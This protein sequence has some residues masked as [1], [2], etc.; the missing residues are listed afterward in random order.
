M[1][2]NEGGTR[3]LRASGRWLQPMTFYKTTD[4]K[5]L[6]PNSCHADDIVHGDTNTEMSA[7]DRGVGLPKVSK[8]YLECDSNFTLIKVELFE[9]V[10][11]Y[12]QALRPIR[13]LMPMKTW[14]LL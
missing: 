7:E 4:L 10:T 8:I 12:E 1:V 6:S 11:D 13:A 5:A 9:Y 3:G 14:V 2:A